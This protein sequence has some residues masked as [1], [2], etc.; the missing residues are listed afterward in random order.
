M[1]LLQKFRTLFRKEKIEADM[2]EEM[3][4]HLERRTEENIAA[5]M[6]PEEARYTALRKFGGAEQ[7][8]EIARDQRRF[9][10]VDQIVQDVRYALRQFAR[11]K[12]FT[13]V[14]ILTLAL[15]IGSITAIY[16]VV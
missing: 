16:S 1:K 5:G 9:M 12:G 11:A 6:P 7:V 10:W 15:G 8:K 14:V 13:A 2:A 4:L 3:R